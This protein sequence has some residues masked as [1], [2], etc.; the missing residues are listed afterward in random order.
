MRY[1]QNRARNLVK[2]HNCEYLTY[3]FQNLGHLNA[4]PPKRHVFLKFLGEKNIF[5][6]DF[7][8]WSIENATPPKWRTA[9]HFS[10]RALLA[11]TIP[12]NWLK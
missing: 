10:K 11:G 7:Q 6:V 5:H 4:T 9:F 1:N 8:I 2:E 12:N 3:I